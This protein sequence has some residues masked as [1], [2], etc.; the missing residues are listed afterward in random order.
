M[1]T[2]TML[3][4]A[5][6]VAALAP[7][8]WA[9][10]AQR[11]QQPQPLTADQRLAKLS[12]AQR[13]EFETKARM[14]GLD[15]KALAA[16]DLGTASRTLEARKLSPRG[17]LTGTTMTGGTMTGGA[18]TGSTS[19]DGAMPPARDPATK[20]PGSQD[21]ATLEERLRQHQE[22]MAQLAALLKRMH[23]T[24]QQIIGNMR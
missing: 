16:Q 12:P 19:G 23:E 7:A 9:Q 2:K 13:A 1:K 10:T 5:A 14:L 8:A 3:L 24:Q 11:V 22:A 4:A 6:L 15:P 18:A 20:Q 17:T 21:P